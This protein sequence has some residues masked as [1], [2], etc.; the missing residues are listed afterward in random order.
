MNKFDF[1]TNENPYDVEVDDDGN[2][3]L[4][5]TDTNSLIQIKKEMLPHN[6]ATKQLLID[7]EKE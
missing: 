6:S 7:L 5:R 1:W 3:V 2:L 4:I